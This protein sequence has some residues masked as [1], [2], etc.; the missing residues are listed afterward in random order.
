MASISEELSY[1]FHVHHNTYPG[2]DIY[3]LCL[4]SRE[5]INLRTYYFKTHGCKKF[6]VT[7]AKIQEA[8]IAVTKIKLSLFKAEPMYEGRLKVIL[9]L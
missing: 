7:D 5:A 8:K 3:I 1:Q 4:L 9:L 2:E 6:R